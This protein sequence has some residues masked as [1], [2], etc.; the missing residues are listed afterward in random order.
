MI[1]TSYAFLF[2]FD[3]TLM[4]TEPA[5]ICSFREIFRRYRTEEEFTH[6]IQ[7]AVLGPSLK[8]SMT[9]YFPNEDPSKLEQEY[10]DYQKAHIK[11]TVK[12][13]KHSLELINTLKNK[14]YKVGL[15]STRRH[16]SMLTIFNTLE[17]ENNYD[18]IIGAEDIEHGKPAPDGILK[19][20]EL[21]NLEK[22]V[23]VGDSSTDIDAGK[24]AGSITVGF[25]SNVH[26]KEALLKKQPDYFTD[27]LID[28]LQI[29][30]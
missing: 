8:E 2:D 5:I 27:D 4:D 15:V 1:D 10:R 30:K 25:L 3:G 7:I 12:P 26:K 14:G 18:V 6:E 24:A 16:D 28:I 17:L 9:K 21:L 23:Y 20:C 29:I 22:S 11:E 13:M 19:A